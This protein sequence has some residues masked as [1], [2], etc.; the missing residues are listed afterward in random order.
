M[1]FQVE[2]MPS[3]N[4]LENI[5]NRKQPVSNRL[6][7][8]AASRMA[9]LP[10]LG[11][12]RRLIRRVAAITA[13]ACTPTSLRP[14]CC[15]NFQKSRAMDRGSGE[16]EHSF[17]FMASRASRARC[18]RFDPE[19]SIDLA[20]Q[21]AV[22]AVWTQRNSTAT[23]IMLESR[24][25][26]SGDRGSFRMNQNCPAGVDAV[27]LHAMEVIEGVE[28]F[29]VDYTLV[30]VATDLEGVGS[31]TASMARKAVTAEGTTG[32]GSATEAE[33]IAL[34]FVGIGVMWAWLKKCRRGEAS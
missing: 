1:P 17:L 5:E 25:T 19:V 10:A 4:N 12:R 20:F 31:G 21:A 8:R 15:M 18:R 16:I 24:S 3:I 27:S 14:V 34:V 9:H 2:T 6:E 7:D 11:E 33:N 26:G 23:A 30:H 32:G 22:V 13:A 29:L 28:I